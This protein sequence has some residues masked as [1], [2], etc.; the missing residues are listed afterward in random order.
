CL[1]LYSPADR[2]THEALI[3]STHPARVTVEAVYRRLLRHADPQ[4][5]VERTPSALAKELGFRRGGPVYSALRALAD[6]GAVRYTTAERQA[7]YVTLH[8][9]PAQVAATLGVPGREDDRITLRGLWTALGGPQLYRGVTLRRCQ[10]DAFPG[11]AAEVQEAL[12]RMQE[13]GL[14]EWSIEPVGITLTGGR[15]APERIPVP[16]DALDARRALQLAKLDAVEAYA[17]AEGCRRGAILAY[18]D[19]RT[20]TVCG[21]CDACGAR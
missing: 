6:A 19:D 10:L 14:L 2:F 4:G 17:T 12:H 18:F 15:Y 11:G 8:A 16:W 13:D 7:L 3:E 20:R 21:G 1:L 5:V 9:T